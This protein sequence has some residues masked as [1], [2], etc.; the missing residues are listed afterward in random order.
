MSSRPIAEYTRLALL[1]GALALIL[2]W[3]RPS[4]LSLATGLP[5]VAL[6]VLVRLWAAGHLHKTERLVTSGPYRYTRNPL[7]LGR[8]FLLVGLAVTARLPFGLHWAV[9]GVGLLLFFAYYLPRKERI[10]PARLA[11]RHG[12]AYRRYQAAVPALFPRWRPWPGGDATRWSGALCRRNREHWTTLMLGVFTAFL[13][14][15][16]TAVF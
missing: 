14:L 2:A 8:L 12:D 4:V 10:E 6:G 16:G 3:A 13:I 15:R 5:F 9:L 7:Y 11:A 1:Y